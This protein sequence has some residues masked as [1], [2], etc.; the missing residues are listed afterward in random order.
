MLLKLNKYSYLVFAVCFFT[1][2]AIIENGLLKKHPENHLI[3][4]FQEQ[5]LT[6]EDELNKQIDNI[7][8][9]ISSDDFD[10]SYFEYLK[11]YTALLDETGLGYLVYQS[12]NLQYWSDRSISFFS[13][14]RE[15]KKTEGFLQ[16]PNGYYMA[17]HKIVGEYEIIG[18]H[19]IK[20]NYEHENKYLKN[21]FS[22]IYKFPNEFQLL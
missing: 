22:E 12:G 15:F 19:L 8:G 16:L 4:D 7:A 18:L 14:I 10:G 2:A 11:N 1:A 3:Q 17:S 13:T 21:S 9:I 6:R 20:H 5:L